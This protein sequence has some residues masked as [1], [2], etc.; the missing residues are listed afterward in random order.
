[1]CLQVVVMTLAHVDANEAGTSWYVRA[2]EAS[3]DQA[4]GTLIDGASDDLIRCAVICGEASGW[5]GQIGQDNGSWVLLKAPSPDC[6]IL[7]DITDK[8][9]ACFNEVVSQHD[10]D[11]N[12][13]TGFEMAYLIHSHGLELAWAA[14]SPRRRFVDPATWNRPRVRYWH[15]LILVLTLGLVRLGSVSGGL[16][17]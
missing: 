15:A 12:T 11:G 7:N 13:P 17:K 9:N 14:P 2:V 1:M 8:V 4:D 6:E 10:E 5:Q 16:T 3:S